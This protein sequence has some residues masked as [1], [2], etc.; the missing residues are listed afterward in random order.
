MLIRPCN[1][2]EDF[3]NSN[4]FKDMNRGHRGRGFGRGRFQSWRRGRGGGSIA[5]KERKGEHQTDPNKTASTLNSG[6]GDLR[7]F[8][9][10]QISFFYLMLL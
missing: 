1:F 5:G 8:N 4:L 6:K 2:D 3:T 9:F 7:L 10:I